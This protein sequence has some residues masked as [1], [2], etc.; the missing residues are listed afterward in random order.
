MAAPTR[1][2]WRPE[3]VRSAGEPLARPPPMAHGCR[4]AGRR[5]RPSSGPL[6]ASLVL[7]ATLGLAGCLASPPPVPADPPERRFEP[8]AP[9]R[10][11]V[12]AVHGFGDHK[13][14]FD[15][16][17]PWLAERGIRLV[18]CDQRGFGAQPDRSFWP[19]AE[20]LAVEL[21]RRVER[22][23]AERPDL[24]L[25]LLGESMGA[26]VV[27]LAVTR[28]PAPPVDGV[29]LVAPAVWGGE[30]M[31]RAYRAL[32]RAIA[33]LLPG[34][35]L[36]GRGLPV[37]AAEDLGLLRA[38][39]ADPLYLAEPTAAQVAGL[40]D[41][42]DRAHGTG[43]ALRVRTLVLVPGRDE[44]VP[45]AVQLAFV[46]T[47]AAVDCT[48]VVHPEARHLLLRDRDRERAWADLFAWLDRGDPPSALARFCRT[49]VDGPE[50][51]PSPES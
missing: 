7:A 27:L 36:S 11:Q 46:R 39:A 30:S 47:I 21:G 2:R 16:L 15:R 8:T 9:A 41:L 24:P 5:P 49:A 33:A 29:V 50:R 1:S 44:I 26:A 19:G 10:A 31:P 32:V 48:L 4:S 17:G 40:L 23:R 22:L 14:A 3:P 35:R 18:A 13:G 37:R 42:M 25:Y 43:P 6:A 12:L 28:D 20:T 51:E 45:T 38:L 34:W